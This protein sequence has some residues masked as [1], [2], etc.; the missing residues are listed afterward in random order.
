MVP[1]GIT[2]NVD[3]VTPSQNNGTL[4]YRLQDKQWFWA[5]HVGATAW[6]VFRG[7]FDDNELMRGVYT[8]AVL[9]EDITEGDTQLSGESGQVESGGVGAS[10]PT[11]IVCKATGWTLNEWAGAKMYLQ[12]YL[13][14]I[15]E[16]ATVESNTAVAPFTLVGLAGSF[17]GADDA[18]TGDDPVEWDSYAIV[19]EDEING[20][21][22]IRWKTPKLIL[23]QALRIKQFVDLVISTFASGTLVINWSIDG[24]RSG[25]FSFD[26]SEGVTS[27]GSHSWGTDVDDSKTLLWSATEDQT[28]ESNFND[29]AE[30]KYIEFEINLDTNSEFELSML[31]MR[32]FM[33]IGNRWSR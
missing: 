21:M 17:N 32:Y 26:L 2:V 12:R 20:N 1:I 14:P 4:I 19:R 31:A 8:N 28:I 16:F 13:D 18:W 27:W 29:T 6:E 11:T 5:P 23:G 33:H 9:Q 24:N 7:K 3:D 22:Q 30:G 25:S 10:S 15:I